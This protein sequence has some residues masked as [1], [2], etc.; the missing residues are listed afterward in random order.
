[1]VAAAVYEEAMINV[2]EV[3]VTTQKCIYRYEGSINKFLLDDKGSTLIACFG[4]PP[5]AH[6]DDPARAVLA[7]LYLCEKLYELGLMASIGITT[8]DVFC[9]VVG[10]KTRR[11][12]TVLGDSVNLSARLMQRATKQGGGVLCDLSCKLA[13]GGFLN[14]D[15]LGEIHVKGKTIPVEIFQPYPHGAEITTS[16][17]FK[18]LNPFTAIHKQQLQNAVVCRTFGSLEAYFSSESLIHHTNSFLDSKRP[19]SLKKSSSVGRRPSMIPSFESVEDVSSSNTLIGHVRKGG[20]GFRTRKSIIRPSDGGDLL[21]LSD[22]PTG[23]PKRRSSVLQS[24][25]ALQSLPS[26]FREVIRVVVP[27]GLTMD[28]LTSNDLEPMDVSQFSTFQELTAEIYSKAISNGFITDDIS[29]EDVRL[30]V[31]GTRFFL[32]TSPHNIKWL[33]A[34]YQ[35]AKS[36][37]H[38]DWKPGDPM[39][40]IAFSKK[41]MRATQSRLALAHCTLLERKIALLQSSRGSVTLLEG[42][43]GVGKTNFVMKFISETMFDTCPIFFA[44]ASSY[45]ADALGPFIA[46]VRQ[47]L[48]VRAKEGK[49][50][51]T[52]LCEALRSHAELYL[53]SP[54]LDQDL[55]TDMH[56]RLQ[57]ILPTESEKYLSFNNRLE[58]MTNEELAARRFQLYFYLTSILGAKSPSIIIIDDAQSLDDESWSLLLLLSMALNPDDHASRL[59]GDTNLPI[60]DIVNNSK[61]MVVVSFR[62]LVTHR[63]VF[64]GKSLPYEAL[65][66]SSSIT[67]LKLDGLPPEEVEE[68]LVNTLHGNIASISEDLY[69]L[70]EHKCMANPWMIK[71]LL[72]SLQTARPPVLHYELVDSGPSTDVMDELLKLSMTK[73]AT[74]GVSDVSL[75]DRSFSL[76]P[77]HV[78]LVAGFSF[79]QCP[80]PV[81]VGQSFGTIFDRLNSCQRMILKTACHLGKQFVWSALAAS[82]PLEGHK[83][84]LQKEMNELLAIG[85]VVEVPNNKVGSTDRTY[86][87]ISDF[88]IDFIS[89]LMLKD[90]K[91]KISNFVTKFQTELEKSLRK[92]FIKKNISHTSKDGVL[93][94]G[95]LEVQK[96]VSKSFW[97]TKVKRRM[98]G[99]WKTRYCVISPAGLSMYR[100]KHHYD[101]S[102]NAATQEIR[103]Q[104]ATA[105]IEPPNIHGTGQGICV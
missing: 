46:I 35:E 62:P 67:F 96:E 55:G 81:V 64:K 14:F 101:T 99:D 31:P 61:L 5:L 86:H 48:D 11:E 18:G 10:S 54:L 28:N 95:V 80:L 47:Y 51:T 13:S 33:T 49:D 20:H 63:S 68:L 1:M 15:P 17:N 76:E 74:S 87:F 16:H 98:E 53:D 52:I 37:F 39:E 82:Y 38:D 45:S 50:R 77:M 84:R 60:F 44:P 72:Y 12:Y 97:K 42:E 19:P 56:S 36:E 105:H 71:E 70:I 26:T 93:K 27:T 43:V 92:K 9:G 41:S 59:F 94:M 73:H 100:D 90:Q 88:L 4:L 102:P 104:G 75:G 29:E 40:L 34:Y 32:P 85:L 103:L 78:D 91:E 66:S 3:L 65:S 7:S 25:K 23:A 57:S 89:V 21:P 79:E 30:M 83:H 24:Y 2:H 69:K 22:S 58:N 6:D 8:G